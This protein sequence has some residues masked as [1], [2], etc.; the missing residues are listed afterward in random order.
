MQDSFNPGAATI[1][2]DASSRSEQLLEKFGYRQELKRDLGLFSSFAL[3]FSII[4]VTTGLFADYGEGLSA[5]GPAF[6][7]TW[8][9]I[10]AGQMLVALVFARLARQIPLSGYA[11]QWVRELAGSEIG[12]WAGWLMLIQFISGMPGVCYALAR[13]L[14]SFAGFPETNRNF[15]LATI[16]VLVSI[17]LINQFGIRLAARVND[18]SVVAEI[19]GTFAVGFLLLGIALVRH[20]HAPSFL[21]T[22]PGHPGGFAYLGAFAFSSVMSAWTLT[23]FEGAANCA[24]ETRAPERQVPIA[25]VLSLASSVVLGFLVLAGFTLA[26]PSLASAEKNPVPLLYI[27]NSYLPPALVTVIMLTV[28]VAIYACALANLTALTRMVWAMARDRQL[29]AS[30]WLG[31]ISRHQV[32][33]NAIWVVTILAAVVTSWAKLEVVMTGIAALAGYATYAIVIGSAFFASRRATGSGAAFSI[34]RGLCLAALGWV[35]LLFC[36]LS[37]PRSA[38][39]SIVALAAALVLGAF[40]YSLRRRAPGAERKIPDVAGV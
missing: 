37:F 7:W 36:F 9:I 35:V 23:G 17:A 30:P 8:L 28:F 21:L 3:S 4:S 20:V 34:P 14:V 18:F 25:I 12:W 10:G 33:A 6:V 11:Y 1:K 26:I 13:Y 39:T 32:P 5:A 19:L 29:P 24:E 40:V 16:A 2:E 31:R 22:H 27:M 15:I 38:R